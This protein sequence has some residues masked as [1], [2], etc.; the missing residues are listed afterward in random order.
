MQIGWSKLRN[1]LQLPWPEKLKLGPIDPD[2]VLLPKI[3]Q[4]A[5]DVDRRQ[6]STVRQLGLRDRKVKHVIS[7]PADRF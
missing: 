5:V 6:P 1:F 7:G 2:K 3:L 4:N